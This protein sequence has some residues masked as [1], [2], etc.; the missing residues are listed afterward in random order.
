M[1]YTDPQAPCLPP[2]RESA[3]PLPPWDSMLYWFHGFLTC[4]VVEIVVTNMLIDNESKVNLVWCGIV[5]CGI[6]RC[7][8]VLC[9]VK[10]CG[11]VLCGVA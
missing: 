10:W 4:S 3:P 1:L 11:I 8:I 7:G 6:V 9:C 2:V 5:R